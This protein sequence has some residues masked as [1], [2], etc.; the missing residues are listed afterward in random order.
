M[1]IFQKSINKKKKEKLINESYRLYE[2]SPRGYVFE[3]PANVRILANAH[4]ITSG[5]VVKTMDTVRRFPAKVTLTEI[6]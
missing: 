2:N 5:I 1:G 4:R 3:F 6:Q